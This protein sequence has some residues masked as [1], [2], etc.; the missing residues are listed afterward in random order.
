MKDKLIEQQEEKIYILVFDTGDEVVMELS[1]FAAKRGLAA[2]QLTGIGGFRD[3]SLGFFEPDRKDYKIIPVD[4]QVEVLSLVG[5]ITLYQG[6][7]K[8]HAHVVVGKSDGSAH[9]GHLLGGHVWPTLEVVMTE[10]PEH[11][12][13]RIDEVTGL[14]LIRW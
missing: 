7:P 1:A 2:A 12:Q 8:V 11:L 6:K 4:E 9:G 13:R 10:T 14:A 3:V 5:T